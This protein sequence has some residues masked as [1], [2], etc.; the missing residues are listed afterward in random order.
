MNTV[1]PRLI[2]GAFAS[3][4][5]MAVLEMVR[6]KGA[7]LVQQ[8]SLV[9]MLAACGVLVMLLGIVGC[10]LPHR[11]WEKILSQGQQIHSALALPRPMVNHW[12]GSLLLS[13]SLVV[14]FV[15]L[16]NIIPQQPPP[17]NNDQAA[18][19]MQAKT[20]QETGGPVTLLQR[21]FAGKYTEANQHPLYVALLSYFPNDEAGKRLSAMCG[22]CALLIFTM[23][24]TRCYGNLIGGITGMLL[25]INAAYC[26]LTARI[27]CEGL[28]LIFV[29]G[30]WLIVL[31]MPDLRKPSRFPFLLLMGT[32]LLL[33]LAWLTKGT[34]LLLML[35]LILWLCSYAVNWQR[36][37]PAVLQQHPTDDPAQRT[38]QKTVPLKRLGLTLALVIAS[39]TVI[40][41]PLLIRNL[42]VYG[43]PTFNANSY[44]LF[45][46]EFSEP[47]A[48]IKQH[49]SLRNAAQNYWQ[50][51]TMTDM[52][53]REI[54]GMLWQA[55]I[56]LRSLGPLPFGEG[57]LFFGLL[58]FP[59]LIVGLF[60]ETGP[61]RRLYL[62]WMLLFWLAF[63]WYLP[64]AAGERFLI[65]LLLPSLAFVSL[66][67]VRTGQLLSRRTA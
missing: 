46:D 66:G 27:V 24:I 5:G 62:I 12:T 19:L 16:M 48:L 60:S 51:H 3:V 37:I 20:V 23:G 13:G 34:A 18:F 15:V 42:R 14:Y 32:G 26:Q 11:F 47:H 63:A 65:P 61:A 59:F 4:A 58:A 39:F 6:L 56:F 52:I 31:R 25:S 8:P 2:S 40:A 38:E 49:G 55:F 30:V 1:V 44:L 33:G 29:A 45:E 10:L 17:D 41:A 53:K 9:T 36:W 64:I 35:G 22:L 7:A 21:L 67:L 57:R 43:S 50:S 28:L 54:K